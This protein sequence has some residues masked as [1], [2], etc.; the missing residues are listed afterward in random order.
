MFS[1]LRVILGLMP[2]PSS[3]GA[4]DA[5]V[6]VSHDESRIVLEEAGLAGE[7][8]P[9]ASLSRV[10]IHTTDAGP[11][12]NDLFWV[13]ERSDGRKHCVPMGSEGETELLT[14]MQHRLHGFDNMAV[15]DAM[16]STENAEFLVW[17]RPD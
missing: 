6:R 4:R 9:W 7:P 11:F 5:P 8:I 1:W 13:L 14:T 3:T 15:V 10:Y 2:A 12:A 17:Q 16:G